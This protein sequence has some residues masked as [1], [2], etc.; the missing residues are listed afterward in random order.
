W[1]PVAYALGRIEDKRAAPALVKMLNG[2]G[3]YSPA[4]A[5]RGLGVLKDTSAVT[6]LIGLVQNR[7]TAMEVVVSAVRALATIADPRAVPAIVKLASDATDP[8]VK[9]QAV[10][11]LGPLK[12]AAGLP[13][14]QDSL[15]DSWPT[16]R[17]T[18]LRA[19]ASIDLENFLLVLSGMEPDRDWTV[20]AALADVLGTLG[21]QGIE[22]ARS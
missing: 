6:A 19:A 18:A 15:T 10:T 1:W 14:V 7:T 21:P 4:F 12:T 8:N 20:R 17:A 5:A 22:R 16:M 2:P 13:V 11:A 3:K 9:L